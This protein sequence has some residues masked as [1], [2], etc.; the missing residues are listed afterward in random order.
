MEP[1]RVIFH[2]TAAAINGAQFD[3][4]N[5]WHKAKGFP[6]SSLSWYVGYHYFIERNGLTRQAREETEIG[7]HDQGEN[8]DSIGICLAGDFNTERPTEAQ[9]A[10][11]AAIPSNGFG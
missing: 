5:Q 1:K 8:V 6:L 10:A 7:A 2:H 3:K 9:A 11:A 4:V